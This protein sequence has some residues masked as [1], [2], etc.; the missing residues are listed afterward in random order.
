MN[1][2]QIDF[3]RPSMFRTL[4]RMQALTM[5]ILALGVVLCMSAGIATFRLK[6]QQS[7]VEADGRVTHT[8][9]VRQ[10][11]VKTV[12]KISAVSPLQAKAINQA[13]SQLNLPWP[14]LLDT[15]EGSTPASIALLSLEPDGKIHLLKGL[16]ETKTSDSML[17]Y[18]EQ[19]RQQPFFSSVVLIKHEINEQDPNKPLRFQFEARWTEANS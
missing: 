5:L 19:L 6:I 14:D 15:I 12:A 17:A 8:K 16:A 11:S 18:V 10:T 1:T 13:T 9:L 4:V 3:A 2:I 7:L